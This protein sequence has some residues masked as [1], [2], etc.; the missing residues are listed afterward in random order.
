MK[1]GVLVGGAVQIKRGG[2]YW[3]G[4]YFAN[5]SDSVKRA[6]GWKPV[7]EWPKEPPPEGKAWGGVLRWREND[8]EIYP[9]RAIVDAPRRMRRWTPLTI[10]RAAKTL[11]IW[12]GVKEK[13]ENCG[14]YDEF[15]AAQIVVEDDP[16]FVELRSRM[17][18]EYGAEEIAAFFDG[19]E[20]EP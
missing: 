13:L 17:M 15:V 6:A 8:E 14:K 5:P 11:G 7:R 9:T 1:W 4:A 20:E 3:G 19:L 18:I 10:M 12:E 16:D 2:L